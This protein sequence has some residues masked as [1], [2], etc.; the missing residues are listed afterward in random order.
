MTL[1][2][3]HDSLAPGDASGAGALARFQALVD[4]RFD[5]ALPQ[6]LMELTDGFTVLVRSGALQRVVAA[7]LEMMV[8]SPEQMGNWSPNLLRIIDTPAL[9]LLV[10]RTTEPQRFIHS[11]TRRQM[12]APLDGRALQF[13]VYEL[14]AGVRLDVFD[15]SVK[16]TRTGT[17]T[18]EAGEI[19]PIEPGRAVVDFKSVG[20]VARL[21][22]PA[23]EPIDWLFSRET[24]QAV[25]G[26]DA[27]IITSQLRM[28]ANLLGRLARPTSVVA[29]ENLCVHAHHSVRWSAV[30]NLAMLDGGAARRQLEMMVDDP[31]PHVRNAA[32]ATMERQ[33]RA[34]GTESG[35]G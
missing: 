4:D 23:T 27:G 15:P 22:T 2:E 1:R 5:P 3:D 21:E 33:T 25:Q 17:G 18:T 34:S 6:T 10:Q 13:D 20:T 19:L 24:G 14:P 7:Q 26:S 28:A 8:S 12:L 31:H 35:K 29:L 30:R 11:T 16:L 32:R 9:R